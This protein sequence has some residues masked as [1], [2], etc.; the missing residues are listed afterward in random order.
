[1]NNL[2]LISVVI[3]S[4]NKEKFIKK[5][6]DSILLQDYPNLEVIV[7]DGASTDGTLKI[8]KNYAKKYPSIVRFESKKDKGQLDAVLK[9]LA[10]ARGEIMTFINADDFYVNGAFEKVAERFLNNP[11]SFWFAGRGIVVDD[12]N[13]EIAKA[14]TLYKNFLFKFNSYALLLMVNYLIQ[15]SVFFSA[16]AYKR[17]GPFTGTP[18]FITEYDLWLRLGKVK[19]PVLIDEVLTGF[20]IEPTTKTMRLFTPLL[21]EDEKIVKKHTRNIIILLI[22]KLNN[23]GRTVVG[24]FV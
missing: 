4:F 7:Q 11:A 18:D 22:H 21:E 24:R 3:P 17:H 9:G 16:K 23:Y 5:T 2:P 19:M 13:R 8:I 15:P 10:K 14:V 1:V 6:L 20:R 12:K